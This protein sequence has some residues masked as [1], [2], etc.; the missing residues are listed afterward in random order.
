METLYENIYGKVLA[1]SD[2]EA[3]KILSDFKPVF[4]G[5]HTGEVV[6]DFFKP[7][8]ILKEAELIQSANKING[9]MVKFIRMEDAPDGDKQML[10]M[11]RLHKVPYESVSPETMH[12]FLLRFEEELK[13]LHKAGFAHGDLVQPRGIPPHIFDNII[14]TDAGFRLVDTGFSVNIKDEKNSIREF[15]DKSYQEKQE[16]TYFKEYMFVKFSLE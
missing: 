5:M 6:P 16:F 4:V 8:N 12:S 10:V 7:K 11:E 13:E 1:L 9:L 15:V 2:T 14:L 3:G